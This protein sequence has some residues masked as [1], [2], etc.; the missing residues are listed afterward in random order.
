MA[1]IRIPKALVTKRRRTIQTRTALAS[2]QRGPGVRRLARAFGM[3]SNSAVS[4][5][6]DL[7]HSGSC[8]SLLLT[9]RG[10]DM[11]ET[12]TCTR[13]EVMGRA[14]RSLNPRSSSGCWLRRASRRAA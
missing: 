13:R 12:G 5:A 7:D 10:A 2:Q 11:A 4:A 14:R 6:L 9:G 8:H 3:S 1:V